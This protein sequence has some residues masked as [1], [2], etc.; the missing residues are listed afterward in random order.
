MSALLLALLALQAPLDEGT[1]LVRQDTAEIG[2]EAF[3]LSATPGGARG[4][5]WTLVSTVRYDRGRPVIVLDPIVELG[6]DSAAT[7]LEYTVAD[8]REPMRILGQ[9]TRGRFVV[10]MLGRRTERAREYPTPPPAAVLDDSVYALYLPLAWLGRAQPVQVTAVFPR[11]GRRELLAVQDL[12]IG[13]TTLDRDPAELRHFTV[14]GG[15]NRL[16]HIWLGA[17]GRLAKVE[18]PSRGLVAA[19]QPAR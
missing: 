8:P 14:T 6:R 16:V 12:G 11:A 19:R 3:R 5:G 9:F 15:E 2:R 1:L 4:A 7:T 10:R 17:E 13:S 18:I